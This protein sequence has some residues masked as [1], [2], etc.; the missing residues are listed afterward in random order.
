MSQMNLPTKQKETPRR[1]EQICSCQGGGEGEGW[2]GSLGLM[3]V[4]DCI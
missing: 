1:R 3:D 4:N 2:T